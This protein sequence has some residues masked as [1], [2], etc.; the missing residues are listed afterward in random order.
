M[1]AFRLR[2]RGILWS[3]L[4]VFLVGLGFMLN[5]WLPYQPRCVI[6]IQKQLE[7]DLLS[8]S[9][10]GGTILISGIL[11]NKSRPIQTWDTHTGQKLHSSFGEP[12]HLRMAAHSP[13]RRFLAILFQDLE[14]H[15]MDLKHGQEPKKVLINYWGSELTFSS[16]GSYLA[17]TSKKDPAAYLVDCRSGCVTRSF[18]HIT[19]IRFLADENILIR[20]EG[21][22][23]LWDPRT[24]KTIRTFGDHDPIDLSPDEKTLLAG[25][26]DLFL[27]D[28]ETGK[29]SPLKPSPF[30]WQARI[31][32]AFSPDGKTLVTH[33][34]GELAVWDV[35][36]RNQR[37]LLIGPPEP[38]GVF[39]KVLFSPD[40]AVFLHENALRD[41]STGRILWTR[42]LLEAALRMFTSDCKYLLCLSNGVTFEK[43]D[44]QSGET[45]KTIQLPG[46]PSVVFGNKSV[47]VIETT[48]DGSYFS[49]RE[50]ADQNPGFWQKLLGDWWPWRTNP[51]D[52]RITV[53]ETATDRI[54]GQ[55]QGPYGRGRLSSDGRSMVTAYEEADGS[56][57]LRCWDL[58]LRPP[59]RLVIGI[60]LGIGL[61][62]V[63]VSWWRGRRRAA[64]ASQQ[65]V[66]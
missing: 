53:F 20:D 44:V 12:E 48:A 21:K 41:S 18:Q 56:V 19:F 5:A 63:L 39:G 6:P 17:V 43:I 52:T 11:N 14:L 8:L 1:A 10:D 30:F 57:S 60:P 62:F 55:L 42:D 4:A 22:L 28:L 36:T 13:D 64:K 59:L 65:P 26:K 23:I 51:G 47:P 7:I 34:I 9:E 33:S 16:Q 45:R 3:L 2:R 25:S 37:Y 35:A 66:K 46:L 27:V 58:P 32:A 15:L 50:I 49:I 24:G 61:F 40:S 38:E 31:R 54:L 29:T